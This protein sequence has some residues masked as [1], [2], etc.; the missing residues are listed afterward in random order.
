MVT[1]K[2]SVLGLVAQ[3][4]HRHD[5]AAVVVVV[6]GM[7]LDLKGNGNFIFVEGGKQCGLKSRCIVFYFI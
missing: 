6:I 2:E 3:M 4:G 7:S 5:N 1:R